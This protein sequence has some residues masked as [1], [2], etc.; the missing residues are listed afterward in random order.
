MLRVAG[1][2]GDG[3]GGGGRRVTTPA[4]ASPAEVSQYFI[5]KILSQHNPL[6]SPPCP[7]PL[8]LHDSSPRYGCCVC[9]PFVSSENR[10][11]PV[12]FPQREEK[13]EKSFVA[14]RRGMQSKGNGRANQFQNSR[15]D[16]SLVRRATC[17]A[18]PL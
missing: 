18:T 3:G 11:N 4:A 2:A 9:V 15:L 8:F 1:A 16:V 10:F 17:A 13:N 5:P 6:L 14:F 12:L 7:P